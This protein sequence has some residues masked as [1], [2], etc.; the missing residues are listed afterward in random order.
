MYDEKKYKKDNIIYFISFNIY[1]QFL[2][3][4]NFKKDKF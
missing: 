4:L 2:N 3:M 1:I